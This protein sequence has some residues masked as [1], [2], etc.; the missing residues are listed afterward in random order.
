MA[1][2][3][4]RAA[5]DALVYLDEIAQE[6]I[7][8][9]SID[10]EEAHGRLNRAFATRSFVTPLE[11]DVLLHEEQDVWAKHVYYGRESLWWLGE[12]DALPLPYP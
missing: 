3:H 8:L 10:L 9:F 1:G 11:V 5:S 6:M 7:S 2:I 4:V 12:E